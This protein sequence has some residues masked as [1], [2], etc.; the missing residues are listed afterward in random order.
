MSLVL[1]QVDGFVGTVTLNHPEKRNALGDVVTPALREILPRGPLMCG[2]FYPGWF[3]TWGA[4]HHLGNTPNYLRDLEIMLK[5]NG[6]FSIYMAH[7]GTSNDC[8]RG[9]TVPANNRNWALWPRR[10]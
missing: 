2:E 9:A 8:G 3:D 6:S 4:P 7:G 1:S 10:P 5:R